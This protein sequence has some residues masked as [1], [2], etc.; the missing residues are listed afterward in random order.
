MTIGEKIVHLR[1]V[2][3]ISQEEL[4]KKL[5]VSRQEITNQLLYFSSNKKV[6]V[7]ENENEVRLIAIN[8]VSDKIR[9]KLDTE[10]LGYE[11]PRAIGTHILYDKYAQTYE[12]EGASTNLKFKCISRDNDIV[13]HIECPL[14]LKEIIKTVRFCQGHQSKR[15]IRRILDYCLPNN[16]IKIEPFYLPYARNKKHNS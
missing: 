7:F 5:K 1:I 13:S 3:N 12:V 10:Y 6:N 11:N 16:N 8:S 4:S 9:H 2:N 15:E 14:R